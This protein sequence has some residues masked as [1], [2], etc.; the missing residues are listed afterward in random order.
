MALPEDAE[1]LGDNSRAL[2]LRAAG[3]ETVVKLAADARRKLA[4]ELA[5]ASPETSRLRIFLMLENVRGS[6]DAVVL[7]VYLN[8]PVGA[9]P[10]DHR[11]LLAGSVALYGLALASAADNENGGQGL[12]FILD[13]T[14]IVIALV[15]ANSLENGEILVRMVPNRELADAPDIVIERVVIFSVSVAH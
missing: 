11:E 2:E 9:R 12:T 7:S 8:L 14:R 4:S 6:H 1:L 15:A 13:T 5:L 3:G 10:G